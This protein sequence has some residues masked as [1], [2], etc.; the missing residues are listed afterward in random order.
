MTAKAVLSTGF[1]LSLPKA[2]C[3]ARGW[4][5]GQKL[6]FIPRDG[7]VLPCGGTRTR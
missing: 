4:L 1:R 2:M 5:P 7:G 3:E 6:A